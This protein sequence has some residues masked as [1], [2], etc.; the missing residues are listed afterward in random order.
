MARRRADRRWRSWT[1]SGAWLAALTAGLGLLAAA[2]LATAEDD[3]GSGKMA[4]DVASGKTTSD[5]DE[6]EGEPA[7]GEATPKDA[8]PAPSPAAVAE[9]REAFRDVA[10]VL[11]S[12]RCMNCHPSGDAP[13]QTD[14]S[15]PH[16]FQISR[17]SEDAG[18]ACSACHQTVN[19]EALGIP[20]GPPGAPNWHLP[21]A[22]T[23]MV[24]Q[25]H[26]PTSLCAQ[27]VDPKRNGGKSL[28]Q[29]LHHVR[30]DPL[31]LWGW[32]PGGN[33][34]LPPLSH[35]AFVE[36]FATWVAGGGACP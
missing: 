32:D 9:A 34:T 25:G 23:P 1:R 36:A 15:V 7:S 28:D 19:S 33:R 30:E 24:F 26:T 18:L 35:D 6:A 12:P 2:T 27:L 4:E 8:K 29:L 20:G 14:A 5:D 13:L 3:R 31:V 10:L 17:A 16:R 22:D 11:Q 21:P